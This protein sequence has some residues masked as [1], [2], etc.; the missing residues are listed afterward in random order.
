[1]KKVI[2]LT[3]SDLRRIVRRVINENIVKKTVDIDCVNKT[4]DGITVDDVQ[5]WCGYEASLAKN[6]KKCGYFS[7]EEYKN[8][9]W[10]CP[11]QV[12]INAKKCGWK[13]I[14]E[15]KAKNWACPGGK[16]ERI[17]Y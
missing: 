16:N 15:Y 14:D 12:L 11:S 10:K 8:A 3:E 2:R 6:A 17:N 13:T 4:I 9:N 1:M 7:D 5:K